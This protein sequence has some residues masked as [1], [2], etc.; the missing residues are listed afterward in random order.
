MGGNYEATVLLIWPT[1]QW[2]ERSNESKLK[3]VHCVW[4]RSRLA[5][6]PSLAQS[7]VFAQ[8][9]VQRHWTGKERMG[10]KRETNNENKLLNF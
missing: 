1:A 4:R 6:P 10:E 9:A 8:P 7:S 3:D 5:L 2:A